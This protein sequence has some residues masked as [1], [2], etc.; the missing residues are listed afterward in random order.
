MALSCWCIIAWAICFKAAN[1]ISLMEVLKVLS[2]KGGLSSVSSCAK[3]ASIPFMVLRPAC[4]SSRLFLPLSVE[5]HVTIHS[6]RVSGRVSADLGRLLVPVPCCSSGLLTP[7]LAVAGG[8]VWD[9][10]FVPF[11]AFPRLC[12]LGYGLLLLAWMVGLVWMS[13]RLSIRCL[14]S[15]EEGG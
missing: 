11:L 13:S 2:A 10:A 6:S 12:F 8:L 1:L 9:M 4:H 15:W 5:A 7:L 3:R 14:L